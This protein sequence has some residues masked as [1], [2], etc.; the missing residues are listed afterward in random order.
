MSLTL[1]GRI[2]GRG[3]YS[4]RGCKWLFLGRKAR[5]RKNDPHEA[6]QL[7]SRGLRTRIDIGD[8]SGGSG[9]PHYFLNVADVHLL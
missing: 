9:S 5:F 4:S 8:V 2:Y 3:W 6:V 1:Q 7:I